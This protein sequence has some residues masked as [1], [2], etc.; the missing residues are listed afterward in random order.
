MAARFQ[1]SRRREDIT[2]AKGMP[3]GNGGQHDDNFADRIHRSKRRKGAG[4]IQNPRVYWCT[5]L[6][7]ARRAPNLT[8]QQETKYQALERVIQDETRACGL[9]HAFVAGEDHEYSTVNMTNV[10]GRIM[11]IDDFHVTVRMGTQED[12]CNLHGHIYVVYRDNDYLNPAVRAMREDE[13]SIKGGKSPQLWVW[14]RYDQRYRGMVKFPRPPYETLPNSILEY[15][16]ELLDQRDKEQK[17]RARQ[18]NF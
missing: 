3:L 9:S 15:Q 13:R 5:P 18:R 4:T 6:F 12:I 14:G 10:G 1:A 11:S 2:W 8:P 7:T 17:A 16:M